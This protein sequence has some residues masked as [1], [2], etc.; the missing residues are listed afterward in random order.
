[1]R[2][3]DR[4]PAWRVSGAVCA[5]L[6]GSV[7]G[8]RLAT[9]QAPLTLDYTSSGSLEVILPSGTTLTTGSPAASIPPGIYQV[10]VSDDVSDTT[11]SV[12]MFELTGPG[13]DL[14]TD[15]DGGDDKSELFSVTLEPNAAYSFADADQAG[16]GA[17]G[18]D[19]SSTPATTSSPPASGSGAP[20]PTETLSSGSGG[21]TPTGPVTAN[22]SITATPSASAAASVH[23]GSLAATVTATGK[24]LL[25]R[26]GKAVATLTE[27]RYAVA[28]DDLSRTRGFILQEVTHTPIIVS[29]AGFVGRRTIN[30]TLTPGQWVYYATLL[31]AKTYFVVVS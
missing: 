15:L 31:G 26:A 6:V 16:L 3:P 18:F 27:G 30:V 13:V 5:C 19:T 29:G 24:L 9:A 28:V 7:V 22:T 20:T 2:R 10:V 17:V 25:T 11:D 4:S 14:Q 8:A 21:S 1:M 12:H 23:R